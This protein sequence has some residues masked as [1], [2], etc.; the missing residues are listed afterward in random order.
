[1]MEAEAKKEGKNFDIR[2]E[3]GPAGTQSAYDNV[4][5]RIKQ[6][7]DDKIKT[8]DG[9]VLNLLHEKAN[10]LSK[11]GTKQRSEKESLLDGNYDEPTCP[12]EAQVR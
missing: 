10:V 7:D 12:H 9:L 11:F 6:T 5:E 8:G 3:F 1:M 2:K 4:V